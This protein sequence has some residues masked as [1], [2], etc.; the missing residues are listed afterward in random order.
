MSAPDSALADA[1]PRPL[2]LDA[3]GE[4]PAR[5]TLG[6]G[7]AAVR[8]R[9]AGSDVDV[10]IVGGG[11]SGLWTAYHLAVLDPSKRITVFERHHVG[12]GASGRNG[13]WAVGEL[14]GSV[15]TYTA[16]SSPQEALR[17]ERAVMASVDEIGQIADAER[18]DCGF[19]AGGS[20]RLARTPPQRRRQLDEVAAMR[21]LGH[22]EDVIRL[23][24]A[25]EARSHLAATNVLG[26]VWFAPCAALDPGRLVTG[27]ARACEARGVVI[28]EGTDV[29]DVT[30]GGVETSHGTI[31]AET[32]VLA[33][34]AYTRDLPGRR[35]DLLPVY[36]YMIA[37]EPLPASTWREIGLAGRPTFAD[38]RTMVIYG[39]RTADDRLAFGATGVPYLFGSRI[40]H[41]VEF[42]RRSA[43]HVHRI[44][45]DLLPQ[46]AGARITHRWGGVLGIP[47]NWAPSIRF[48]R[49]MR[50]GVLGGYV[51]EGVA[52]AQLA[53]RTMAELVLGHDTVR[54]TL[55]WVDLHT[56]R[57]EPEPLR[58]IG[59]RASRSI[60]AAADRRE[61]RTGREA[62]WS[63][64][65]ARL[66]RGD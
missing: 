26:G 52:A 54:T 56:R 61:A 18:I 3:L 35:R 42:G 33:T 50:Q 20:V 30:A 45:V 47:R 55:P 43:E 1:R 57:W 12:F 10:A 7:R 34:E 4:L 17:L 41:R 24:D 22:G 27:L 51:G 38:D 16:R 14:A 6:D 13:G 21:S 44:L 23:L 49:T 15:A 58:W 39:Q 60:L 29:R 9:D 19:A 65:L 32:S 40:D 48:D 46:L 5:T 53:G 25:D 2:W 59:V 28:R 37:T 36:S 64:G 31:R 62:R 8:A 63:T 11:F 66:L